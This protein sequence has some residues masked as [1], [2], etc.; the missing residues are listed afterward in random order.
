MDFQ[1]FV[2]DYR[3]LQDFQLL[4][5]LELLNN[6][7][8]LLPGCCVAEENLCNLNLVCQK[9]FES[10]GAQLLK[11]RSTDDVDSFCHIVKFR[12]KEEIGRISG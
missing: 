2:G 7:D 11:N 4:K 3:A 12:F 8:P 1:A 9:W 6:Q 5:L 10:P